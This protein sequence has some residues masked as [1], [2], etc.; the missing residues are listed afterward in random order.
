MFRSLIC[1]GLFAMAG[2]LVM[3]LAATSQAAEDKT[4]ATIK[5]TG[6]LPESPGQTGLFGASEKN[7]LDMV[8][9]L[10]RASKDKNI[11][12]VLLQLRNPT[13]GRGKLA[14]L[15]AAIKRVRDAG[16]PVIAQMEMGTTADYM[17]AAAC[18]SISMPESG[19]LMLPGVRAEVTFMKGL[20]DLVG[21]KADMM[22]VGDYK[23][24]AEP[25]TRKTMSQESRQ[26]MESVISD[27]YEQMIE[28]IAADRNLKPAAVKKLLD[29]GL[30]TAQQAH[31]AKLIDRVE[32][33]DA[34]KEQ[35]ARLTDSE[36][37]KFAEDYGKKDT[38]LDADPTVAMMKLL[39]LISG[40]KAATTSSSR[41]KVAVVYATGAITSG[42]SQ[43]SLL[44]GATMGSDTIIEALRTAAKDE[45][46]VAIVLRVDS[47]GGSALASDLIWREIQRIEKPVVAS[48]GDV[49][50][51]GGYYISMG[52]DKIYAEP[53]TLTGSIGVVGGKMSFAGVYDKVGINTEVIARGKNSG[54][55][56]MNQPFTDS[57]RQVWKKMMQ[58][59]YRQFTTK[60]AKGRDMKLEELEKLA[61]G[62][63]F[64]GRQAASNGLVDELGTLRDA[65]K[66]AKVAGGV[67]DGEKAELLLLPK[68][69]S[70]LEQLMNNGPLAQSTLKQQVETAL[71]G[72][73]KH[74]S[75]VETFHRLFQEP[76]V[77]IM[78]L[79]IDIK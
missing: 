59:V 77:L 71:P 32:Y 54:I 7:L 33:A 10:D 62:R 78:P 30:F 70:F 11:A 47:P 75:E 23:G 45:T 57:E 28:T 50:G 60:A 25:Y 65:L 29:K 52:C 39:E 46:V 16:K 21:V 48:M 22:Q 14:E 74:L 66:Y 63:I 69:K 13:L 72:M 6:S 1:G 56:S 19:T 36:D 51:S 31:E 15:R 27:V 76:S 35:F 24:A 44:G 68:P 53:G 55:L 26:Q 40:Q 43:Q 49:A 34:L 17:V 4:I 61:G 8:T 20:L 37:V 79:R 41:K 3:N 5:V 64:S 9:R 12:G 2:V 18:D 67:P 42:K 58:E 38:E 73:S